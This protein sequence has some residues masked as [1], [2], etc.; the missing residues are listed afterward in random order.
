MNVI[1]CHKMFCFSSGSMCRV[2]NSEQL[3][4]VFSPM[5]FLQAGSRENIFSQRPAFNRSQQF[6]KI[7]VFIVIQYWKKHQKSTKKTPKPEV[8]MDSSGYMLSIDIWC[9][10]ILTVFIS[11]SMWFLWKSCFCWR[12]RGHFNFMP[13][14]RGPP[15]CLLGNMF[16]WGQSY[17]HVIFHSSTTF[18]WKFC[19]EV[20]GFFSLKR[21]YF[22]ESWFSTNT[23]RIIS[24]YD[25]K[26]F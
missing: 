3:P 15:Q 10:G 18:C 2:P 22:V 26:T 24:M 17:H 19:F 8:P 6:C 5:A 9:K 23:W 1:W 11:I 13:S 25:W 20:S 16:P 4:Q 12:A 7:Y 14:S 21:K